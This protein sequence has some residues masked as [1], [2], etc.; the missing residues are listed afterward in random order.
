[1]IIAVNVRTDAILKRTSEAYGYEKTEPLAHEESDERDHHSTPDGGVPGVRSNVGQTL[2]TGGAG[3]TSEHD[4][5][6]STDYREKPIVSKENTVFQGQDLQKISVTVNVPR[7]YFVG[8]FKHSKTDA[9]TDPD[10]ATLK[11]IVDLQLAQIQDQVKPLISAKDE[12]LVSVHM[13]PDAG[14]L[15]SPGQASSQAATS[16]PMA[17]LFQSGLIAPV[18]VGL[19]V[20]FT[21]AMIVMMTRWATRPPPLPSVQ[22]LA[23]IPS[24]L[25]T[26]DDLIG[27]ADVQDPTMAG[28]ELDESQ[29]RTRKIAEQIG[30]MVK[31]NPGEAASLFNRWIRKED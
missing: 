15:I 11:P 27:E 17:T 5:K 31:T 26:D 30:E 3:Q 23:G 28:V 29:I 8:I 24:V 16:A 12:G 10:D 20:L 2:D 14:S 18:M 7:S 1:M 25:P 4:I 19:L 22:E 9:A 21:M 6:T 13:I